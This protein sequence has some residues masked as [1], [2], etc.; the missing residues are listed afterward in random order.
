MET[1]L[2]THGIAP[3]N[4]ENLPQDVRALEKAV[5]ELPEEYQ[6]KFKLLLDDLVLNTH[7]RQ[8]MMLQLKEAFGQLRLDMKYLIFD[9]ESTTRERDRYRCE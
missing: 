2:S 5:L 7:R 1:Y 9:L 8:N 6:C 3:K 4:R